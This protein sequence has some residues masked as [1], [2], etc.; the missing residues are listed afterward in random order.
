MHT[1]NNIPLPLAG[2]FKRFFQILATGLL[3]PGSPALIDPCDPHIRINFSLSFE[4]MVENK[5]YKNNFKNF[6]RIIFVAFLKHYYVL[7]FMEALNK[8]L[9]LIIKVKISLLSFLK[10]I[11]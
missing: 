9:E 4:D 5:C 3:L 6:F 1:R 8:F 10:V 2:A 7:L 11:F